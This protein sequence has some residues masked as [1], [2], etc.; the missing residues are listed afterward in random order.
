[1]AKKKP[2]K[3]KSDA[4]RDLKRKHDEL[5][6]KEI[7]ETLGKEG[8]DVSAQ[9]VSTVLSNDRKKMGVV[10]RRGRPS[11]TVITG[12]DVLVAKDLVAKVGGVENAK[13]VLEL[14]SQIVG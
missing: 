1:M 11:N 4:I 5:G 3:T 14:Y 8:Y 9:F 10:G 7:A 13:R 2:E 12:D 6:P